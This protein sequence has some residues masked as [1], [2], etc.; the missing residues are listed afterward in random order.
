M[1]IRVTYA[2]ESHDLPEFGPADFVAFERQFKVSAGAFDGNE[3]DIRFEWICF[4]VYRGLKRAGALVAEDVVGG[5][6]P[7]GL[8][9]AFLDRIGDL[10]MEDDDEQSEGAADPT[11]P[12]A[13]LG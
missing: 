6:G 12:A 9:E 3:K 5:C 11:V 7:D 13:P 1:Q 10:E 8:S 4:L 2:G